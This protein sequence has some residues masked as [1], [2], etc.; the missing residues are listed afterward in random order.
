MFEHVLRVHD[1][2]DG[3]RAGIALFRGIPHSFRD[4]GWLSGDP[5]EDRFELRPVGQDEA[6]P[7]IVHAKFRRSS[8]APDPECPPMGPMDVEWTPVDSSSLPANVR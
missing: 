8:T 6:P 5:D 2:Y 3:I 1:Y 4:L 7:M